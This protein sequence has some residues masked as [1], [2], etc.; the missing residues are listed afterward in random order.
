[1]NILPRTTRRRWTACGRLL[2]VSAT[3]VALAAYSPPA[4]GNVPLLQLADSGPVP[5]LPDFN[6]RSVPSPS[7][8]VV[9]AHHVTPTHDRFVDPTGGVGTLIEVDIHA[10]RLIAWDHGTVF[11]TTL[12]ST[13]RPGYHTPRGHFHVIFKNAMA[14]SKQWGV[15]MPY[16]LNFHGDYFIHQLPHYPGSSV[17]I[18]S[19]TLGQAV[20][21][22]CVR[23]GIPAAEKLFDWAHVGTPVW[24]HD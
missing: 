1:M 14:W 11:M 8:A 16:A 9:P 12:I 20:S 6:P 5:I 15:W 4:A 24:V 2:A 23:V 3:H 21:H 19:S 17:N 10:Q 7:P 18:G 22:G 13:A